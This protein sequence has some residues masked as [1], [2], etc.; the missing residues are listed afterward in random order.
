MGQNLYMDDFDRKI[1]ESGEQ[2]TLGETSTWVLLNNPDYV[3]YIAE[4]K[5]NLF[6]V[7]V[8]QDAPIGSRTPLFTLEPTMVAFG[9]V[10]SRPKE[11]VALL[12]TGNPDTKLIRIRFEKFKEMILQAELSDIACE[13][14]DLWHK[15]ITSCAFRQLPPKGSG[16]FGAGKDIPLEDDM[17]FRPARSV[18]WCEITEG[19]GLL[20][21]NSEQGKLESGAT[22]IFSDNA[23]MRAR[24]AVKLNALSTKEFA[25]KDVFKERF[26]ETCEILLDFLTLQRDRSLALEKERL[27][28]KRFVDAS[29]T[30]RALHDVALALLP[31]SKTVVFEEGGS[32]LLTVC[33]II[34]GHLGVSFKS[35]PDSGNHV[36]GTT[37]P[38][39]ELS[40]IA[41]TARIK[42][43]K[44]L[45]SE[46]W[47]AQDCGPL[48]AFKAEDGSPVALIPTSSVRYE[49]FDPAN[50]TRQKVDRKL[51]HSL[52]LDAYT[53]YRPLP[54]HKLSLMDILK[55]GL[56]GTR[57]GLIVALI[58]GLFGGLLNLITPIATG[59]I[60]NTVIPDAETGLLAQISVILVTCAIGMM[61]FDITESVALL[62]VEGKSKSSLE[63]ALWDRLI[64]FPASFFRDY[65]AGDLAVRNMGISIIYQLISV[66]TLKTVI[67]SIFSLL[68]LFL[69]FHYGPKLAW[70]SIV[71]TLLTIIIFIPVPFFILRYEKKISRLEGKITGMVLQFITGIS[72]L[73]LTGSEDRAFGVWAKEFS[74]K[75]ILT[76]K[77][78][79]TQNVLNTLFSIIPI[80]TLMLLFGI[81]VYSVMDKGGMPI[82]N[83]M[84]FLSAN[85]NFM[86]A[87]MQMLMASLLIIRVVPIYNR[88]KPILETTPE[89]DDTKPSPGIL[90]GFIDVNHVSFRYSKEGP[91]IL[92]DV[93][94]IAE[95]GEFIAIVG[96]SGSGKSTLL[97]LLLGFDFPASGSIFYDGKDISNVDVL[98]LRRQMGVVLQDGQI[99]QSSILE[100]I[101]GSTGLSMKE[102]WEAA[103]MAGCK[104]DIEEMPMRM[105]TYVTAGGGTLS[106]GQRQRILIARAIIRKPRIILFDEATSALDNVTQ[107]IVSRS[108]EALRATR[109]V[110]AHRLSTIINADRI[111]VLE[112]GCI[113]ESGTYEELM[114]SDGL[115]A[116]LAQRQIA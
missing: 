76:K 70:V 27:Q 102:A 20:L 94:L 99:L 12:G 30:A 111:Y 54:Q 23:W 19:T 24:G 10:L 44:L 112:K 16:E 85:T 2:V 88:L 74:D 55:F 61:I 106:G 67:A 37:S 65:T 86:G 28:E 58:M 17:F 11:T 47:W 5:V 101:T 13:K 40:R 21:D 18:L 60:F 50:K 110:I 80:V 48:L 9:A 90:D 7:R 69:L 43:R 22:F 14:L 113:I 25:G 32:H 39:E 77:S 91:L 8:E 97:R 53:F 73:R 4:G 26:V 35:P 72:K 52:G 96:S 89:S 71:I 103:E 92:D 56:K 107:A 62:R 15:A 64:M 38:F 3:W 87:I 95:P 98:E 100:N 75:K 66:S 31:K 59:V 68:N 34:G 108:L 84:A 78:R 57:K 104:K 109:V 82:G 105:H 115:F 93:S 36:P 49:M 81:T 29:L 42:I 6:F 41:R 1:R 63:A 46:G 79:I 116:K 114:K 83:F 45:L 33:K 51:A